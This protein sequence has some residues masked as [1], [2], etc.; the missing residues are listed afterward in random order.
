VAQNVPRQRALCRVLDWRAH[1]PSQTLQARRRQGLALQS[2]CAGYQQ[3]VRCCHWKR[4]FRGHTQRR[5]HATI[6]QTWRWSWSAALQQ[7]AQVRP[8]RY[9]QEAHSAVMAVQGRL[10][11]GRGSARTKGRPRELLSACVAYTVGQQ[12]RLPQRNAVTGRGQLPAQLAHAWQARAMSTC[13]PAAALLRTPPRACSAREASGST[14]AHGC[15]LTSSAA[16]LLQ[17]GANGGQSAAHC[18]HEQPQHVGV[19]LRACTRFRLASRMRG[20]R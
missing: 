1:A 9:A 5:H 6:P 11:T 10:T 2:A 8:V 15:R 20:A 3:Q 16:H 18:A 17:P 4:Q 14:A 12:E 7:R 13:C 19:P